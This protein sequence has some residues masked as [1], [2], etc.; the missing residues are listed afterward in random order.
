LEEIEIAPLIP[1][2][3]DVRNDPQKHVTD[4]RER[5]KTRASMGEPV[6]SIAGGIV[7]RG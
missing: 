5:R 3:K 4:T 2:E 7:A 1:G 6:Y